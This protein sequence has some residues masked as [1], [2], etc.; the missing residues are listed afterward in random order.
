MFAAL[1][2]LAPDPILGVTLAFRAD[3]TPNKVDLGVGVYRDAPGQT[4]DSG[5]SARGRTG[6]DRPVRRARPTWVRSAMRNSTSGSRSS[7]S[8]RWW[9]ACASG[10]HHPDGG[11]LRR[12]APWRRDTQGHQKRTRWSTS[13]RRPGRITNRCSAAPGS[14]CNATRTTTL[15]RTGSTRAHASRARQPPARRV[16]L[17]HG[18]CH[19]PTGA[20]L[21]ACQWEQSPS[22]CNG[23]AHPVRGPGLPGAGRRPG[24]STPRVAD[25]R[26]SRARNA[27]R[28][29]LLEEL[30]SLSRARRRTDRAGG[31]SRRCRRCVLAPGTHRPAYVFRCRP[32]TAPRSLRT[33]SAIR[34]CGKRGRSSSPGCRRGITACE[35]CWQ[36]GSRSVGPTSIS[37]GCGSSRACS[38]CSAS[39]RPQLETLRERHHVYTPPDSRINVAGVSQANVDYVADSIAPLL[40]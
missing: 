28:D 20:D 32:I 33:C 16:V 14:H 2:K 17:L 25:H 35:T 23:V 1:E 4:P 29:L 12:A 11:R 24:T 34:S 7:H 8:G 40:S 38:R 19:N 27:A 9:R 31:E 6:N 5:G 3:P 26:R 15:R 18:C 22:C 10:G 30:W 37:T 39:T 13:A 36:M 21:S